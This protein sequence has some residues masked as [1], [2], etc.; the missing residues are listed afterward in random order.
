[1]FSKHGQHLLQ[2]AGNKG[3]EKIDFLLGHDR[4]ETNNK[5]EVID[6]S[7]LDLDLGQVKSCY[8][9]ITY[10]VVIDIFYVGSRSF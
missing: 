6:A 10:I 4:S 9:G 3:V 7:F 2:I 1:M 8:Q 5:V